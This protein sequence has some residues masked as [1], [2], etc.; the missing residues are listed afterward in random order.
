MRLAILMLALI[1]DSYSH[2]FDHKKAHLREPAPVLN[3]YRPNAT[4]HSRSVGLTNF[5]VRRANLSG[6][7]I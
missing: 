7:I 6:S 1:C 2:L 4:M 3:V 5:N